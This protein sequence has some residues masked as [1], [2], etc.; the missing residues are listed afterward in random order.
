MD[1]IKRFYTPALRW[2]L[3]SSKAVV[4]GA[5]ILLVATLLLFTR[6]GEE[7]IPQ[8]DEGEFA[9]QAIMKP[10]TSLSET[11]ET[12]TKVEQLILKNFLAVEHVL[13]RIGVADVPT[14]P[15]PMDIADVFVILK[16]ESEWVS[17]E[18]KEELINKIKETISV[19]PGVNY[20]FT[21]PIEMRD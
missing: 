9:F 3:R 14:D 11:I 20:E 10:G 1:G 21:Q 5:G 6:M 7:F 12:S 18:S 4:I 17:A 19:I 13:S 2:S 16:P 8:L 15:M